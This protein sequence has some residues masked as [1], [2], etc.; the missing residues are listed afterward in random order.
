MGR[1]RLI[2]I[3]L[4][5]GGVVV[6]TLG[7]IWLAVQPATLTDDPSLITNALPVFLLAFV[8]MVLGGY[9]I[10]LSGSS[11]SEGEP[12]MEL[13]LLLLDYLRQHGEVALGDAAAALNVSKDSIIVS[14]EELQSLQL[15][16]GYVQ[17]AAE[18][19]KVV[20]VPLLETMQQCAVC[21][22][23]LTVRRHHPTTCPHCS[24]VYYLPKI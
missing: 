6:A 23:E 2:G 1:Q 15:F 12:E 10:L 4:T 20:P 21:G 22:H 9:S 14:L 19:V 7:G 17:P 13:P 16:S 24:T 5:V 3:G 11:P 18:R 8:L